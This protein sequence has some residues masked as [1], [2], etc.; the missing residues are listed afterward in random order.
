MTEF[1]SYYGVSDAYTKLRYLTYIMDVATPTEYCLNLVY[2]LMSHVL[3]KENSRSTLSHQERRLLADI[4]DQVKDILSLVFENYK[5]LDESSPTGMME[6][7]RPASGSVAP[8]LVPAVKLYTLLHDILSPEA[9]LKFCR[10]FQAATKKR[11]RRHLAET[12]EFSQSNNGETPIDLPMSYKKMK[13]LILNI[14]NEVFTDMKIHNQQVLPSF[15][16]LPNISSSLYSVELCSRLRAFL[17]TYPP[18]ALSPPVSEL[19]ITV[20]DFQRDLSVWNVNPV[21][22]GVDAKELF[23]R[24]ITLWIQDKRHDLLEFCKQDKVKACGVGTQNSTTPFI[25]EMFAHL[26]ATIKEYQIILCRWPEYISLL[27]NAIADVEK[28]TVEAL[29]KQFGDVLL[30][31]KDNLTNKILGLKYVQRLSKGTVNTY[32]VPDELGILLNSMRRLLDVLCLK[33]ESQMKSWSSCIPPDDRRAA[34]GDHLNDVKVMLRAKFRSYGQ[35]IVEKL[36]DN[37]KVQSSTKLKNIIRDSKEGES[38]VQSRMQPLRD[39]LVKTIHHLDSVV[40]PPVFIQISRELWERMGQDML[41]LLEDGR[42]KS[43]WYKGLRVAVSI[44]D[45]IFASEMQKLRGNSMGRKDLEPPGSIRE[46]HSMLCKDAA[47]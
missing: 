11:L 10:Y 42:E 35:A 13:S 6:V 27:E 19:V 18:P 28:A 22:G 43:S 32:L 29:E 33:I 5:S 9:R 15:I 21:N 31:L 7:F 41:H 4:E 38:D 23:N 26:E 20:A 30:P 46:I 8:A 12:D 37:T 25:D 16:E 2:N 17:A 39:L 14:G 40:E 44:L 3:M 1:A 45:D 34:I 47:Y 36:A 24:H